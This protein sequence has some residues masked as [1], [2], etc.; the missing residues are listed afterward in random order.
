[1]SALVNRLSYAAVET[2]DPQG[3][4]RDTA[5]IVGARVV[6]EEDGAILMSSNR[7]HAEFLIRQGAE[8]RLLACGLEATS[9]D[10]VDE[11]EARARAAGLRILGNRP[12]LAC[13]DRAVRFASSEGHV[14]EVHTPM[15]EDRSPRFHGPGVHPRCLDHINFTAHDPETW[16]REMAASC[17]FLLSE[18][19]SGHEISWMRAAD[20]R[21]HTIAAVKGAA[22]LHHISWEFSAFQDLKGLGDNLAVENRQII[23][24][25]GRHGAGDNLF[26]YYRDQAGFLIECIAEMEVIHDATAP[27]RINDPG[28]NLSNWRVVNQWGCLPPREWIDHVTPIAQPMPLRDLCP[29]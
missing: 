17:G 10:A 18:R 1:M 12:S 5:N 23:W 27:V 24:G 13:I 26:L 6:G 7:R 9:A 16:A 4:A 19:T 15:P 22:G 2:P 3:L 14:F 21:H 25:P 11:V 8:S 20:G 29:A 28:E